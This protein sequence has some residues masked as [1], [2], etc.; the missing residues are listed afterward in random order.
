MPRAVYFSSLVPR[1]FLYFSWQKSGAPRGKTQDRFLDY[2]TL[3]GSTLSEQWLAGFK[4]S[5]LSQTKLTHEH[6][7][8][9]WW[10]SQQPGGL[11]ALPVH[12]HPR[13]KHHRQSWDLM[14]NLH[15]HTARR[16]LRDRCNSFGFRLRQRCREIPTPVP[17]LRA[18]GL[19]ADSDTSSSRFSSTFS[20]LFGR[21]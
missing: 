7:Q 9:P 11:Q 4:T 14:R 12:P 10:S 13:W 20:Q 19:S 16:N 15:W 8:L 21:P 18:E 5:T 3:W 6:L 17:L 1:L 2:E